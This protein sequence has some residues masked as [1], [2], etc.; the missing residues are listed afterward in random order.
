MKRSEKIL[1]MVFA[2]VFVV[3]AGGGLA[4][5]GIKRYREV[6]DDAERLEARLS[7][8]SQSIAQSRDWQA[9]SEWVDAN[10]PKFSSH[11]EA[12]AR[13]IQMIEKEAASASLKI[14]GKEMMPKKQE[15]EG[16][17]LGYFDQASVKITVT[18]AGEKELFAWMHALY[19][20]RNFVGITRLQMSPNPQGKTVNCELDVTQFYRESVAT[21]L[22][23]AN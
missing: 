17:S 10:I 6:R 20:A 11:E 8:M 4:S 1:L 2:M 21:K 9:R 18:D 7:A 13:L 23:K 19:K 14:S 3:V 16:E 15:K 22:S 12:S 5:F